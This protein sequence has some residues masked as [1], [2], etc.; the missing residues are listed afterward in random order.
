MI[1]SADAARPKNDVISNFTSRIASE[2]YDRVWQMTGPFGGDVTALTIDPR[3]ANRILVGSGDGQIYSSIDGGTVWKR[4]R[5]GIRA[6]S[7]TVT[8]LHFDREKPNLIYA[9]AKPQ[10][11][12]GDETNGGGFFISEDNGESWREA[13]SLRGRA[14]R[15]FSQSVSEPGVMAIAASNGVYRSSD[16]GKTWELITPIGNPELRGFHSVAI[17]P[18]DANAVYVGTHHL[19]WKTPDGGKTWKRTGHKDVGMIDDSDIF[20][21]QVDPD[22]PNTVMMS[23]CSG[24]YRSRD[25]GNAWTKF[26]GIPY[27]SRRTHMVYRHP[28]RRE[29]I[30]AAT[31]E[32]LW[33]STQDGK[34]DTWRQVTSAQLVINAVA[35]HPTEPD[36]VILGTQDN[37]VL[38]SSNGGETFEASN[39]GFINRK[40]PAVLADS[41]ERGRIYAGV[42]FDGLNGGLFVSEDGGVTWQQSMNG[43]GVRDVY[44]LYQSPVKPEVIYAGTNH[45]LFRSE[46]HGRNW[47]QLKREDP[48]ELEPAEKEIANKPIA[49]SPKSATRPR[50]VSPQSQSPKGK[51]ASAKSIK[52]VVQARAKQTPAKSSPKSKIAAKSLP[53][54]KKKV[55][56]PKPVSDRVDLQNQVLSIVPFTASV[57]NGQAA[58][59]IVKTWD[60]FFF[61]EDEAKGWKPLKIRLSET[62]DESVAQS[63]INSIATSP[64]APG[65]LYIATNEGLFVSKNNGA[66]FQKINFDEDVKGVRTILMDPRSGDTIYLGTSAGFFRSLDAGKTW[67]QRGGGMPQMVNVGG[68]VVSAANPE[69][70]YL[71]DEIR[72]AIFHSRDRGKNWD[73]M[74][75]SQLPSLKMLAMIGDPFDSNRLY[76]GSFSGGVYVMSRK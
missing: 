41:K 51:K 66:N 2:S 8:I 46:D 36:R 57:E 49:E 67:E 50:I 64:H 23:A 55:E 20:T 19:P 45:G 21:I 75:I 5:P 16:R 22:D 76:A 62:G 12:V 48:V 70:L 65:V 11:E 38:I 44:S 61:T 13:E 3:N 30:F 10:T 72:L 40:V 15:S 25:A 6:L 43:M 17:D 56:P 18:R 42:I 26:Q 31:T 7:C 34:Q 59:L 39:A 14:V 1:A 32:G 29:T 54:A 60:G 53:A 68:L 58:W 63:A 47:M 4:V 52:P 74:D 28:T 37:G 69:E 71:Y 24:I 9:G 27:S 33:I 73:K 35:V